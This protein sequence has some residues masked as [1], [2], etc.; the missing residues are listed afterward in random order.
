MECD[1]GSID[2]Y[3]LNSDANEEIK[4]AVEDDK[5]HGDIHEEDIKK[6]QKSGKD[7]DCEEPDDSEDFLKASFTEDLYIT[8]SDPDKHVQTMETYISYK[9]TTKT[10]RS[11][12]DSSEFV[13]RRR[14]QD[15]IWLSEMLVNEYPTFLIPP[16]PSKLIVKGLFDKFSSEFI[17]TRCIALNKFLQRIANHPIISHSQHLKTFLT[18]ENF[19]PL[20]KQGIFSRVANSLRWSRVNNPEF[21]TINDFVSLFGEKMS[22]MDRIG[23][24]L[25]LEK[26]QLVNDLHEF[27]PTL[28]EWSSLEEEPTETV[29]TAVNSC[30]ELWLEEAEKIDKTHKLEVIPPVKE[31]TLYAEVVKQALKRRDIFQLQFEKCCE[32]LKI[33][34]E[35]K[36]NL[37]KADQ[38]YSFGALMGKSPE[39]VKKEKEEKLNQ[40]TETLSHHKEE[41]ADEL[42]KANANFKADLERWNQ[43]KAQDLACMLSKLASAQ[44]SYHNNCSSS[45]K[46]IL[47]FMELPEQSKD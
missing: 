8:V 2:E 18:T 34:K 24:R 20:N 35:E 1:G 47:S 38:S 14:Y 39:I 6:I 7:K 4:N 13:V 9:V 44:I 27:I 15:F 42:A 28:K 23:E 22:V 45:W 25:S 11:T 31:Y 41:L 3:L 33:K 29:M 10:T 43:H 32:E 16:L 17:K 37:P 12:F 46:N 21:E 36:D 30:V 5:K 40:Q 26:C 19:V